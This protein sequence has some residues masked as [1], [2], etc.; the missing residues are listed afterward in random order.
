MDKRMNAQFQPCKTNKGKG[1]ATNT[2]RYAPR[3]YAPKA[4][5]GRDRTNSATCDT[6]SLMPASVTTTATSRKNKLARE[7]ERGEKG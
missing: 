6:Y 1:L 3:V 5:W 2:K 7:G 4:I